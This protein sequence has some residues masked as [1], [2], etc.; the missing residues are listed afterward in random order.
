[1]P[2]SVDPKRTRRPTDACGDFCRRPNA[3]AGDGLRAIEPGMPAPAGSGLSRRQFVMRASGM[4]IAVYGA[5]NS[6]LAMF[7]ESVAWAL[8]ADRILVNVFLDGGIDSLSVLC[9]VGDS[10]YTTLR[11]T[12]AYNPA[13]MYA[14]AEDPRLRWNPAAA[15]LKSLYD[16]DKMTVFPAISYASPNHSHFTSRHYWEVGA[17]DQRETTGWLG[18]YLD[19][20]GSP[21]NPLQGLTLGYDL[22]P[23]LATSRNPVAA[24]SSVFAADGTNEYGNAFWSPGAWDPI[25]DVMVAAWEKTGATSGADPARNLAQRVVRDTTGLRNRISALTRNSSQVAYPASQDAFVSRMK[26]LAVMLDAGLG[27]QV[28]SIDAPGHYDTHSSQATRF[29]SQLR[30]VGDTLAAFQADL[31]ARGIADRVLTLVWS[32]FGRRPAENGSAG[33]DHGAGGCAFL[34]GN[35]A[36]PGIVG[37]FPGLATLD[38]DGNLRSTVDFRHV[39]CSLLEDWL[40]ADAARVI[41]GASTMSRPPLIVP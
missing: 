38:K 12:L 16:A 29:D 14:L 35:H 20:Y 21:D 23:S 41:P 19:E 37:E 22:A 30:L 4:A 28:V 1:M 6:P 34:I 40:G 13:G 26:D 7:E 5:I 25:D 24:V 2:M 11:P 3:R 27:I 17:L 15:G 39:Y 33:T 36:M 9:P 18:R 10:R 32:E 31:E 8:P